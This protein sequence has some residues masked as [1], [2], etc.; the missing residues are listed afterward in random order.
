[1]DVD[2]SPSQS[3]TP[4]VAETET[5]GSTTGI[6]SNS[7]EERPRT[8]DELRRMR[9][10]RFTGSSTP[11]SDSTPVASTPAVGA[12]P[13]NTGTRVTDNTSGGY[14]GPRTAPVSIGNQSS[15]MTNRL[16]SSGAEPMDIDRPNGMY[17]FIG[18]FFRYIDVVF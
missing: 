2:D 12:S 15:P 4:A 17:Y 6:P 14:S 18:L 5:T 13:S 16:H 7:T 9:L 11:Q 1:M 10:Q 3:S 8:A